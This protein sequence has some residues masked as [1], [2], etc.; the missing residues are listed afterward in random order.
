MERF[1]EEET[2]AQVAQS[3]TSADNDDWTGIVECLV[4]LSALEKNRD[5]LETH[6]VDHASSRICEPK[7]Y[8]DVV[9]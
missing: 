7:N 9:T 8:E 5:K 2:Q 6:V 3:L 1:V 4:A